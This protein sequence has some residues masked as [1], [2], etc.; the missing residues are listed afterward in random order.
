M[1][2]LLQKFANFFDLKH[3]PSVYPVTSLKL[4]RLE[5]RVLL[6]AALSMFYDY[7]WTTA[8]GGTF[9]EYGYNSAVDS[10]GNIFLSSSFSDTVDLNPTAGVDSYTSNGAGDIF[11]TKLNPNSSYGWTHTIGGTAN[12]ETGD[13]TTDSAGNIYLTGYFEE[14]V[15]FNP[16]EETEEID[17]HTSKGLFDIFVT[18]FNADGSYGWTQ[19]MG[20]N[21]GDYGSGITVDAAGNVFVCGYFYDTVDFDPS[22]QTDNH[23]S[24]GEGDIF[25]TKLNPDGSYAWT[26]TFGGVESESASDL[27]TDSSGN[28]YLT[29]NFRDE[30]DFDPGTGTDTHS[31]NGD[32]DTFV[33]KINSDG[34]YAWT[35]TFGGIGLYD[36]GFSIGVDSM[37]NVYVTGDFQDEVDFD[38]TAGIDLH[39]SNGNR[40]CFVTKLK[41]DGEYEWTATFG[42]DNAEAGQSLAVDFAGNIFLTGYFYS[43]TM[44]F[45]PSIGTDDHSSN[46][47]ADIFL[48]RLYA[49]GSYGWTQTY[50]GSEPDIGGNITLDSAGNL[51]VT[52]HFSDKV[53]FDPS[54]EIDYFT[55][56]G[57]YDVFIT[58]LET[59]EKYYFAYDWSQ[60]AGASGLDRGRD[61]AVDS[62]GNVYVTGSFKETVDFDPTD[63]EDYHTSNGE[64]DIFVSRFHADG[65]YGWTK[66]FGSNKSDYGYS[67]IVDSP[68]QGIQGG[69]TSPG[70][71]KKIGIIITGSFRNEVDFNPNNGTD[72][73]TSNGADDIFVTKLDGNGDYDWT[74]TFGGDDNDVGN[75]IALDSD[76]NVF[77][78]GEYRN[79]VDFDPTEQSDIHTS[80]G[81]TDV[82]LTRIDADGNYEWTAT[83][84]S[85]DQDEGLGVAVDSEGNV[86]LTG[87]FRDSVDF[88][89]TESTDIRNTAGSSDAFVTRLNADGSY[90]WTAVLG[91]SNAE[92]ANAVAIDPMDNIYVTGYFDSITVDFD[93]TGQTD[94]HDSIGKYDVFVTKL[95]SDGSY[96]WTETFGSGENDQGRGLAVDSAGNVYVTGT[97]EDICDFD[98]SEGTDFHF[99]NG[100]EDCYVTKLS[101]DGS[102][103]WTAAFGG[104]TYDQ[105]S[106]VALDPMGNIFLTGYFQN[107]VDLDPTHGTDIHASDGLPDIYP[108]IFVMKLVPGSLSLLLDPEGYKTVK[109]ADPD[110]SQVKVKVSRGTA[111]LSFMGQSLT[112]EF[113]RSTVIVIGNTYLDNINLLDSYEKTGVKLSVK[114]AGLDNGEAT[115]GGLTGGDLGKLKGKK[116]DLTGDIDL[117]GGLSFLR[118]DDI[119]PNVTIST[120]AASP[121][122][123]KIK[124]DQIYNG[125]TFSIVDT[126]KYLKTKGGLQKVIVGA[127]DDIKK[128]TTKGGIYD[129]YIFAGYDLNVGGMDGLGSGNIGSISA[130]GMFA[131]SYISAGVLPSAPDIQAILPGV[132]PPYSGFGF[133]GEIGKVK[134]GSLDQ[135]ASDE[136]GLWAAGP[137]TLFKAGGVRYYESDPLLNLILEGD[138]G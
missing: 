10:T 31:S 117:T 76:G 58:K 115:L 134:F 17:I 77:I 47:G 14:T 121:K 53:D 13:I 88:D 122:G 51:I 39:T 12:E 43:D 37:A 118:L 33:T 70:Q 52:G 106:G 40:D 6:N 48:T 69:G 36:R 4:E 103:S 120:R 96:Y 19:T 30:V 75:D 133:T 67:L 123:L 82:F 55:S 63:D 80:N 66:T 100:I 85:T 44:D 73:H 137:I 138:L 136:F 57:N 27:A 126:I 92:A 2:R 91:G 132:S 111:V 5:P 135:N 79:Q 35:A 42:G 83:L 119:D 7:D 125:V 90:A 26:R 124:A 93:P 23:T 109:Y 64:S 41:A 87:S 99:S 32:M 25:L 127:R 81:S 38:P 3:K 114:S 24:N 130:K 8:W 86:V 9:S 20:G 46:G 16:F 15:D 49:D 105:S 59:A 110:G 22:D 45:D 112:T 113:I 21:E 71:G 68:A 1:S 95:N 107:I 97:F 54:D 102:Y 101:S 61:V 108:D 34:S 104:N 98:P 56:N 84:G 18:K 74:V 28:I 128:I 94:L 50:G 65:S 11:I 129:S 116:I 62:G 72:N 78:V 89:P 29:G 131:D 60:T